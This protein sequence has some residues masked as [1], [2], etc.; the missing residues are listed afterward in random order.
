MDYDPHP[1]R[2]RQGSIVINEFGIVH[3]KEKTVSFFDSQEAYQ[4]GVARWRREFRKEVL[5]PI[6]AKFFVLVIAGQKEYFL[7]V[8]NGSI[9]SE[10]P[11][12]K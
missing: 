11:L 8:E 2:S 3:Y 1:G 9:L 10:Q 6:P 4:A 5:P 12:I 7:D